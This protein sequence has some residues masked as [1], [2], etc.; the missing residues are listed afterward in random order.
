MMN[1]LVSRRIRPSVI[2]LALIASAAVAG[3]S[4]LTARNARAEEGVTV[5]APG[6]ASTPATGAG[7]DTGSG[8]R[9]GGCG[10]SRV[11]A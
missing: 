6:P 10:H 7:S 1:R 2:V 4:P 3:L 9:G 5:P 11:D 8:T